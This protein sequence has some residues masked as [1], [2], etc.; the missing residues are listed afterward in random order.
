MTAAT[1]TAR[2]TGPLQR[3]RNV[4]V[5]ANANA[6]GS[7]RD[8]RVERTADALARLGAEVDVVRTRAPEEVAPLWVPE[9]GR[10]LVLVG[11]DGTLH[12][13]ANLP[14][15]PPDV[16]LVPAG[17]ANNV[18]HCLGIPVEPEAAARLALEGPVRPIDLIECRAGTRR[19]VAVEGVSVGFLALA[20]S[21]Y[22]AR[23]SADVPAAL[24]AGAAALAH[25]HPMDVRLTEHGRSGTVHIGQL[26]VANMACF[27]TGMRIAPHA[28]PRDGLLDVVALDIPGRR[29]VPGMLVRL[30]RGT[31]LRHR[32]VRRWPETSLRIETRGRSPVV[33]DTEDLGPGPVDVRVLPA[34]LPLVA[35]A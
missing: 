24:A 20:R 12:S 29:A 11:G 13:A 17:T 33:A 27:G 3:R 14:G 16:A 23:N 30:R 7:S 35:P 15:P 19:L 4:V 9:A 28:D 2:R 10:L 26:F 25:F 18:A 22:H 1:G 6:H 34:A 32:G 8:R 21:R 5:V 31:H